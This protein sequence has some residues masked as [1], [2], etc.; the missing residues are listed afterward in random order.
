MLIVVKVN[1]EVT[2]LDYDMLGGSDAI[3]KVPTGPLVIGLISPLQ[4]SLFLTHDHLSSL[5]INPKRFED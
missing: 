3:G 5:R 1:L 4:I 2:V